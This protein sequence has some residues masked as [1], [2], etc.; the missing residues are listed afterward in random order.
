V[1][2][3]ENTPVKPAYYIHF[4]QNT[5][6]NKKIVILKKNVQYNKLIYMIIY[7]QKCRI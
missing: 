7:Y 2:N 1:L 6:L 4:F 5:N 3:P